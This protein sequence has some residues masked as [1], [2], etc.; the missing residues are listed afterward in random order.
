MHVRHGAVRPQ[1]AARSQKPM[2]ATIHSCQGTA[3]RTRRNSPCPSKD[4]L[5]SQS[6]YSGRVGSDMGRTCPSLSQVTPPG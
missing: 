6:A 4:L 1:N 2:A 5:S 3:S